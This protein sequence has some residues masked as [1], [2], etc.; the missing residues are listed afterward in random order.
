MFMHRLVQLSGGILWDE[1]NVLVQLSSMW[2][3]PLGIVI[4]PCGAMSVC[5]LC[6]ERRE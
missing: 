5:G 3:V 4:V 6:L 1:D 2:E